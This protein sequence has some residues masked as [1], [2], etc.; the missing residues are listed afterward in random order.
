MAILARLVRLLEWLDQARDFTDQLATPTG[1]V[2]VVCLTSYQAL[3]MVNCDS[4]TAALLA[5]AIAFTLH[6][7]LHR[8]H[9]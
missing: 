9:A 6:C 4:S 1:L 8:P 5:S 2:V 7:G 3:L